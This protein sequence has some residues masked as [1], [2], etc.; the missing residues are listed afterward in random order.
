MRMW[1][2]FPMTI[3]DTIFKAL[4]PAIPDK[5]IAGHHADLIVGRVNG[6]RAG[7]RFYIWLGGLIGGG[8]GAKHGE[9]RH[10]RDDRINDGDTITARPNRSRR[11]IPL[12]VERYALGR[13]GRR[14]P[15]R[16]GLGCEQVVQMRHDIRFNA[17]MDRARLPALGIRGRTVRGS[18]TGCDLLAM[19][20]AETRSR[21]A[22]RSTS[23]KP[24]T[25]ISCAPEAAAA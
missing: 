9:R 25:P 8:W 5:V 11:N 12:L 16:G 4:A 6:R 13:F 17:Q 14:R 18:A 20:Q 23:V 19:A 10:E 3:I 7:Q 15:Y 1:M 24:A 21:T 22:R 2:T